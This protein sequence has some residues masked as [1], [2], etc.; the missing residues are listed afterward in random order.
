MIFA[1]I[2][3]SKSSKNPRIYTGYRKLNIKENKMNQQRAAV[4]GPMADKLEPLVGKVPRLVETITETHF[5][6]GVV[7]NF[8]HALGFGMITK[9]GSGEKY[10]VHFSDIQP[11]PGTSLRILLPDWEVEFVPATDPQNGNRRVARQV[12]LVEAAGVAIT[13]ND[14][15]DIINRGTVSL[16]I[17]ELGKVVPDRKGR[18]NIEAPGVKFY[19]AGGKI[20]ALRL[21]TPKPTEFEVTLLLDKDKKILDKVSEVKVIPSGEMLNS[22]VVPPGSFIM[23]LHCNGRLE[24]QRAGRRFEKALGNRNYLVVEDRLSIKLD[25]RGK[26][27]EE[28]IEKQLLRDGSELAKYDAEFAP[29]VFAAY[30]KMQQLDAIAAINAEAPGLFEAEARK[31]K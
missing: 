14:D 4:L 28:K 18:R 30:Q 6:A 2:E 7:A 10:F 17:D 8:S 22:Q 27:T 13:Q 12:R 5:K 9:N 16:Y 1:I 31:A 3:G 25:L 21:N 24:V 19:L 26:V 29:A 11:L 20:D 23:N 15:Y